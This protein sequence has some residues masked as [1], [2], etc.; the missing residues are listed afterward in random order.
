MGDNRQW[1]ESGHTPPPP[2][3]VPT[4]EQTAKSSNQDSKEADRGQGWAE[5]HLGQLG[6]KP[7][8]WNAQKLAGFRGGVTAI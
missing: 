3:S 8:R 6:N 1:P 7:R 2:Q 4:K 5:T